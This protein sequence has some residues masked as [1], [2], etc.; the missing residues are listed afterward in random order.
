MLALATGLRITRSPMSLPSYRFAGGRYSP[1]TMTYRKRTMGAC[2][3]LVARRVARVGQHATDAVARVVGQRC[4][5]H[6]GLD[7][8]G[9]PYPPCIWGVCQMR[10]IENRKCVTTGWSERPPPFATVRGSLST[11]H[12]SQFWWS[13]TYRVW[14]M[15]LSRTAIVPGV[16]PPICNLPKSP[17][18]SGT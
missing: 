15:W 3:R 16:T 1:L 5:H 7:Q 10:L 9:G 6:S 11:R 12:R 14:T 8:P 13:G 18:L 17:R 4:R 2:W